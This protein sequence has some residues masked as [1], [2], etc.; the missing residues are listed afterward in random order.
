MTIQYKSKE[1]LDDL[2]SRLMVFPPTELPPDVKPKREQLIVME[3]QRKLPPD[4]LDI[5]DYQLQAK[6][7][8]DDIFNSHVLGGNE[9]VV[10][11]LISEY[12]RL[13]QL[14]FYINTEYKRLSGKFPEL[15]GCLTPFDL[16]QIKTCLFDDLT[17]LVNEYNIEFPEDTGI[18]Q[19]VAGV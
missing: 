7:T 19:L 6:S 3:F 5:F 18:K 8:I 14:L 10:P 4:D 1:F 11:H 15:R 9:V 16:K 12:T 17:Q 13:K 2:V